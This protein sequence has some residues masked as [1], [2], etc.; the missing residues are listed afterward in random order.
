MMLPAEYTK[1]PNA[2]PMIRITAT[3][4]N[5]FVIFGYVLVNVIQI[6]KTTP[7]GF[8]NKKNPAIARFFIRNDEF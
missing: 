4:Y 1:A 2:H 5:K 3:I 8:A 6:T 7:K